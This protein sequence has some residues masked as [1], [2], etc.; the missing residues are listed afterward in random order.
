MSEYLEV[1]ELAV[2]RAGALLLDRMGRVEVWQKGPADL[3][4]DADLAA[5]QV[6]WQTICEAFPDH[7]LLAEEDA[8]P[9]GHQVSAGAFRWIADPLDGTTNYV[10]GV[11]CFSV[12]LALEHQGRL[13]VAAVYDPWAEECFTASAGRGAFCNKTRL[14]TSRV[15]VMKDALVTGG[16][17]A[18]VGPD[19]PDL[20]MFNA[21]VQACQSIRR[22]GSAALN[23]AYVAAGR[24]DAAWS[25]S[26]RLWDVAAGA[27]LI[28]EAGGMI[29]ASDGT[30][31]PL[32]DGTYLAAATPELH[33]ELTNLAC[34][35]I[36]QTMR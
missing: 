20:K 14:R 5:Q 24:F 10:H 33:A 23:L 30:S 17:P 8:P 36:G 22:M 9:A 19:S 21:V 26:T 6:I 13:L 7:V 11:P 25:F 15:S 3:V 18:V 31:P 28:Q 34:R 2:R 16:L 35:A 29:T 4:T 12:S 1:C 27:L 32:K